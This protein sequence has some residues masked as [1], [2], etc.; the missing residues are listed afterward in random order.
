MRNA[1]G[2]LLTRP[3]QLDMPDRVDCLR[4]LAGQLQAAGTLEEQWLG[5]SL[6]RWLQAGGDLVD[7]LGLRPPAGSRR[8]AQ[9][10]VAAEI[11]EAA[12]LRLAEAVGSDARA[13][14][15][16]RRQEACP[17]ALTSLA[18]AANGGPCSRASFTR[19]RSAS[20]HGSGR[21]AF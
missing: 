10:I 17:P 11:H 19:V 20:R 16:L 5:R 15:I 12:L 4:R 14:R 1:F 21:E 8:T 9:A 18:E 13:V 3:E 7:V 6:S 2:V